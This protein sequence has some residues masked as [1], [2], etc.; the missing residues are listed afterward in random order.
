MIIKRCLWKVIS[1][2]NNFK[3]IGVSKFNKISVNLNEYIGKSRWVV[4]EYNVL[5]IKIWK[6]RFDLIN[7]LMIKL[8]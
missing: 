8:F 4:L 7:Y 1:K 6:T 5:K 3:C 2:I